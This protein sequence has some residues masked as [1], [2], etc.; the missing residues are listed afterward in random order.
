MCVVLNHIMATTV[1]IMVT[2]AIQWIQQLYHGYSS[3]TIVTTAKPWL[4]QLYNGYNSNGM[5]T[6][7]MPWLQQLYRGYNSYTMVTTATNL[8]KLQADWADKFCGNVFC[9]ML[10]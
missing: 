1:I 8:L 10:A 7:A 5:V 9:C 6:T 3:Y 4:Q 2:T